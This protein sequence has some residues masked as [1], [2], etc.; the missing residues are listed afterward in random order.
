M[1]T[2][3]RLGERVVPDDLEIEWAVPGTKLGTTKGRKQPPMA[4]VS[5]ISISGLQVVAPDHDKV[6]I[7]TLVPI[8]LGGLETTVRVRWIRPALAEGKSAYGAVFLQ[9]SR[10]LEELINQIVV[11]CRFRDGLPVREEP[12]GYRTIW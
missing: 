3:R 11:Q 4:L 2:N 7:G 12:Q 1:M 9:I 6:Q 10:E 5:D 8:S